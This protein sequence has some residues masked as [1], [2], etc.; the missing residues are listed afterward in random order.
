M[1]LTSIF[2]NI[3][4]PDSLKFNAGIVKGE[5][6]AGPGMI[7]DE[8]LRGISGENGP[9]AITEYSSLEEA[10]KALKDGKI[11]LV[12]NIPKGTSSMLGASLIFKGNK[13]FH[14]ELEIIY[15]SGKQSSELAAD[16]MS[17]ILEQVNLEIARR[18]ETAYKEVKVSTKTVT[19]E[20][21]ESFD[22]NTF[23]FPGVLLM[24]ILIASLMDSPL[25]LTFFRESGFNKKVYV[26]PIS[27]V[28]Y[29]T[30]HFMKVIAVNLLAV[31]LLYVVALKFY[32]VDRAI[33]SPRF[34]GSILFS[35]VVMIPFGL[36]VV[37]LVKKSSSVMVVGQLSF[38]AMM[39]LGGLFFPV[40]NMPSG[41]KIFVYIVPT[42]YLAELMR[43]GIG[44]EIGPMSDS[45]LV[46]VPS[47]WAIGAALV[48][49]LNFKKVMGYE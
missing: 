42:T 40:F 21:E 19:S 4:N 7:L 16:I 6:L 5:N 13:L 35:L 26:T 2:G 43:R 23:L 10:Q 11:E 27:P 37:S 32:S 49:V 29:L 44:Y 9:F 17:S 34:L 38:Q 22:Y 47:L 15:I 30:A 1:L 36:M 14:A 8:V 45:L 3:G 31:I 33:L 25:N 28:E 20:N 48:F 41:M 24:A 18:W 39:F 12:L 46:L